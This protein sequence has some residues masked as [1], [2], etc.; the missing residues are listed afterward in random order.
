M[1]MP[2]QARNGVCPFCGCSREFT[3]SPAGGRARYI[4]L[5]CL[6]LL[7]AMTGVYVATRTLPRFAAIQKGFHLDLPAETV[8]V[9]QS[10]WIQPIPGCLVMLGGLSGVL[11]RRPG[12]VT[13]VAT[14][15]ALLVAIALLL[16]DWSA[17]LLPDMVLV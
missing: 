7:L 16:L 4:I 6:G 13:F 12:A 5:T 3:V 2:N 14:T 8:W 1:E 9:L 11:R 17:L 15:F 10:A